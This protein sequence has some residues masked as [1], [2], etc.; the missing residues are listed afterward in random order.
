M[1]LRR[2]LL[3]VVV[4]LQRRRLLL[5]GHELGRDLPELLAAGADL[6]GDDDEVHDRRCEH[7]QRGDAGAGDDR[8]RGDRRAAGAHHAGTQV[9][10]HRVR[11]V[12]ESDDDVE[13]LGLGCESV[14]LWPAS[15]SGDD[16]RQMQLVL[17]RLRHAGPG[18][19]RAGQD[20]P[21]DRGGVRPGGV[22]AARG[23]HLCDDAAQ[24][25]TDLLGNAR[26]EIPR[27]RGRRVEGG[28]PAE[29]VAGDVRPGG[30]VRDARALGEPR[31]DRLRTRRCGPDE[32]GLAVLGDHDVGERTGLDVEDGLAWKG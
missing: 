12:G 16:H 3:E 28:R 32:D 23:L 4:L 2:S 15:A 27:V 17:E 20:D 8:R 26:L 22:H 7:R 19:H 21:A 31:G 11:A 25:L 13:S 14:D 5:A 6:V 29:T 9:R 1:A 10:A 24:A 18:R 30:F